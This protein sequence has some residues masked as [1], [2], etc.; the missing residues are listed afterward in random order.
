[1]CAMMRRNS[2]KKPK[3]VGVCGILHRAAHDLR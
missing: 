2:L 1:M 3:L